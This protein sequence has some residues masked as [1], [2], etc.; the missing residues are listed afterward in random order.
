MPHSASS[1]ALTA[2]RIGL[3]WAA[4]LV[5][6]GQFAKVSVS[7]SALAAVYPGAGAGLG[8]LL[9][10]IGAVGLVFGM[11]A[12]VLAAGRGPRAI[13]VTALVAAAL[14]SALQ[15]ALPG[16]GWMLL[17]RVAEGAAHLAVV[18]VA[19]T[20]IAGLAGRA[21]QPA[22]LTLW[23]T[24]F[25][26]AYALAAVAAPPLL[27]LGG[28]PA[29]F[30]AHGGC[31]AAAAL[32]LALLLPADPPGPPAAVPGGLAALARRSRDAYRDP[33]AAVPAAGWLC[34]TLVFVSVL[35]LLPPTLPEA[36]RAVTGAAMPLA[37]VAASL[38]LG[39]PLLRRMPAT[40]VVRLGFAGSAACAA[41][42]GLA[43]PAL[44]PAAAVTLFAALGLVQGA[45]FAA[46][47]QLNPTAAGRARANGAL[48]QSGNLGN[49]S[50]TPLLLALGSLAGPAALPGFAAAC[51]L[52]GAAI[53]PRA[54]P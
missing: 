52:A 7:F 15:A 44:Q 12:G 48:A 26:V 50:G 22:A 23:S 46:V 35:T 53:H 27:A 20:L 9:G 17:F 36:A 28:A 21:W 34:Y 10:L 1:P 39:V 2:L 37:S 29:V 47:P 24:F 45:T 14:L 42:L 3:L 16:F 19:P 13:L 33:G 32:A 30:L 6:A 11:S 31:A 38:G 41:A 8:L 54:R 25:A 43:P 5:A 4:G 51:C 40:A 18:V 49:L